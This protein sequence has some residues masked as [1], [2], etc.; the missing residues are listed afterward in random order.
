MRDGDGVEFVDA[1]VPPG[2]SPA[3]TSLGVVLALAI[4][5][6][7]VLAATFGRAHHHAVPAPLPAPVATFALPD[8]MTPSTTLIAAFAQYLPGAAI[9]SERT[10]LQL[11]HARGTASFALRDVRVALGA[12]GQLAL[13]ILPT[14][15]AAAVR[16]PTLRL[17]HAGYTFDFTFTG[18][19]P[20]SPQQLRGLVADDRLVA[21]GA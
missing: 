12:V 17:L 6:V 11:D 21:V 1:A 15:S 10:V 20:L 8:Q 7:L 5:A 9:T 2:P 16:P 18:I 3:R 14:R 19:P 4:V 13:R